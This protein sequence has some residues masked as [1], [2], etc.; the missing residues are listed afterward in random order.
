VSKRPGHAWIGT[1]G[2]KQ[3]ARVLRSEDGGKSWQ[4]TITPIGHATPGA[5]I[6]SLAFRDQHRGFAA[7]SEDTTQ[8]P[9]GRI[10]ATA[11][12]GRTWRLLGEP[13]FK[14]TVYGLALIPGRPLDLI[15]TGP[16]GS[17]ISRDDGKSW[18][19]LDSTNYWTV[20][21]SGSHIG[22]MVGPRGRI[23]KVELR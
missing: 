21:F 9:S 19:P 23:A 5:G 20:E 10:A 8:S 18:R 17:S 2:G 11:D 6:F 14:G 12:G 16:G 7:G 3:G 15:A 4:G 1:T 22:W 13:T